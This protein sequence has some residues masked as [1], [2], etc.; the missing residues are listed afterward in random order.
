M[1]PSV[2]HESY[3]LLEHKENQVLKL[4]S[5][6]TSKY[7]TF[8]FYACA[9]PPSSG[10][11]RINQE[12]FFE[13]VLPGLVSRT[14]NVFTCLLVSEVNWS[15]TDTTPMEVINEHCV[16][17]HR[18]NIGLDF[19]AYTDGILFTQLHKRCETD[20]F[21]VICVN[22][23]VFG[24]MIPWWVKPQPD[25]VQIL[26]NMITEE[27][28]LAGMSINTYSFQPPHVQSMV[29]SFDQVALK[30]AWDAEVFRNR[31]DKGEIIQKSE[32][33]FSQAILDSGYN[34]D[35]LEALG[36]GYDYRKPSSIP[37]V[38][39]HHVYGYDICYPGCYV[40]GCELGSLHPYDSLFCK[41]VRYGLATCVQL[42]NHLNAQNKKTP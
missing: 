24:P 39:G 17:M 15:Q 16:K 32:V 33:G 28:K 31:T 5:I 11:H 8:V 38:K 6:D 37:P 27:V 34:I 41:T 26:T 23:T 7:K 10:T 20:S 21:H 22:D 30:I 25:W 35:C 3:M 36:H 1:L 29:M 13:R 2:R 9:N 19:G 12:H 4:P 42:S 40:P 18:P 14:D